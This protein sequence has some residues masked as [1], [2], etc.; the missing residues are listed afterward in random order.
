MPTQPPAHSPSPVS[1][2]SQPQAASPSPPTQPPTLE[3][4]FRETVQK[5]HDLEMTLSNTQAVTKRA[6]V[7]HQY[8]LQKW[9]THCMAFKRERDSARATITVL[10]TERA[11]L[12]G[13]EPVIPPEML[14]VFD[15]DPSY[16]PPQPKAVSTKVEAVDILLPPSPEQRKASRASRRHSPY[17]STAGPSRRLS[18]SQNVAALVSP[19]GGQS[20]C[21][22]AAG[23]RASSAPPSLSEQ[24]KC[25]PGLPTPPI[26]SFTALSA[27][28]RLRGLD[29]ATFEPVR[30]EGDETAFNLT[31]TREAMELEYPPSTPPAVRVRCADDCCSDMELEPSDGVELSSPP[32]ESASPPPCTPT[33]TADHLDLLYAPMA[34]K[35]WCRLCL[36]EQY[37]NEERFRQEDSTTSMVRDPESTNFEPNSSWQALR[38]HWVTAH[39]VESEKLAS[40]TT[41]D[42]HRLRESRTGPPSFSQSL[43]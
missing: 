27:E 19:P 26:P 13:R 35:V 14:P 12:L 36:L 40:L 31:W 9:K 21:R 25:R 17:S 3:S 10:L 29:F 30:Q 42:I 32:A 34:G 20:A 5:L 6:L 7:R 28:V 37:R 23:T 22:V 41:Q 1:P 38:H 24:A 39:P 2:S 4:V 16:P 43:Q 11:K 8:E 33:V 18:S 15:D